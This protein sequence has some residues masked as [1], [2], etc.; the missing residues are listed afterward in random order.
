M[1][2]FKHDKFTIKSRFEINRLQFKIHF[3]SCF[4]FHMV[5]SGTWGSET[6]TKVYS[7]GGVHSINK[8]K[9]LTMPTNMAAI[10]E[11]FLG[12]LLHLSVSQHR[13]L[14]NPLHSLSKFKQRFLSPQRRAN[15][16]ILGFISEPFLI[17]A[18][19]STYCCTH[20]SKLWP[21]RWV[22]FLTLA[23]SLQCCHDMEE[24]QS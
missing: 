6:K 15:L 19:I 2:S 7:K 9:I 20:A 1:K 16:V 12:A 10:F 14:Q 17:W 22:Q 3:L 4:H 24:K 21:T 8:Y 5:H 13:T 11:C 18:G 23:F